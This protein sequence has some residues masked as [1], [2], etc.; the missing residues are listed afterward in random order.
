MSAVDTSRPSPGL[1]S[2]HFAH[3]RHDWPWVT[4]VA[5]IAALAAAPVVSIALLAFAAEGDP[6]R[7]LAATVLPAALLDT[8]LLL[9]G[10]A[11]VTI[12]IGVSTAWLVT[13][14]DFPARR[15][16]EWALLLPLAV[17]TYI[18]AYASVE[19]LDYFGPVQGG[20]R[21]LTGWT[22]RHDYW[23]PEARSMPGA[24]LIM[25]LVLYPY[26]YLTARSMFLMQS[27]CVLDVARTL[28]SSRRR[29][30]FQV[31][32]PL[33][34]PAIAV[35]VA[36]ALMEAMNDIGAVEY[37]GVRTLTV[38]I[39]TTWLNRGSLGGAAQ[40]ALVAL[41]VITALVWLERRARRRQRYASQAQR[42]RRLTATRLKGWRA[43]VATLLALLPILLGFAAPALLLLD[44][45][46]RRALR[47]GAPEGFTQALANTL[48]LAA[49]S[50]VLAVMLGL[51]I[52]YA[53]RITRTPGVG[54]LARM[55]SLGYAVPGTI[56]AVGM[57]APLA[58]FDNA[59]DDV[60]RRYLGV[61]TGL[62]LSGSGFALVLAYVGRYLAV[63]SGGIE[64]GFEK[65]SPHLDM[66]ARNLG[67]TSAEAVRE[68]HL[69]LIR[70]ALAA[71]GLLVFVD[72]MKEL[73]AT[74]LL[75]PFNFD[76]LATLVY[77]Q[78][79]RGLFEDGAL[80]ALAIVAAGLGPVILLA[81][82]S[83]PANVIA[84]NRGSAGSR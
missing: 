56:F 7:H 29:A 40:I 12:A 10:V 50:A 73:S 84:G 83:R 36:L 70:P 44:R 8:A 25:G 60:M 41:A 1:R 19:I 61:A 33:A 58:A 4:C 75:R 77:E 78:A 80:A 20:L 21:A 59:L 30:F 81:G 67:R 45:A 31:A 32:L 54:L 74:L 52:A 26:V 11:A 15:S 49:A 38:S 14:Y 28:G 35:G 47:D 55:A 9:G 43:S 16:L 37:L 3:W 46:L 23:F 17:P 39:Y 82:M 64:A 6:W 72:A 62:L 53:V 65:V 79:S 42:Q 22:S 24:I 34:R 18:I 68:I 66:A 51:V 57:L 2:R 5:V 13:A 76:T 48:F 27:S 63:A 71:A 69:P